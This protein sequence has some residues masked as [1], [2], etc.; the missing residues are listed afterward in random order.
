MKDIDKYSF[1]E[2]T[3]KST[4]RNYVR[5]TTHGVIKIRYDLVDRVSGA[6]KGAEY[7]CFDEIH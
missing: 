2:L 7:I 3:K 1:S 5:S 6:G 4:I